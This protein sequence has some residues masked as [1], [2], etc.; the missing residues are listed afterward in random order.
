M[1]GRASRGVDMRGLPLL[2]YLFLVM[3]CCS[4]KQK[5]ITEWSIGS[6]AERINDS[7]YIAKPFVS[8]A[9]SRNICNEFNWSNIADGDSEWRG[10]VY[11][12]FSLTPKGRCKAIEILTQTHSASIDKE[13]MRCARKTKTNI[14]YRSKH[15]VTVFATIDLG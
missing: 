14:R 11:V 13:I 3:G 10:K 15:P 7:L 1:S 6:I 8:K 9:I 2:I 12:R 5:P 4:I